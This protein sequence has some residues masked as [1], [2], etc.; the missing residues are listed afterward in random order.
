MSFKWRSLRGGVIAYSFC[1]SFTGVQL[2]GSPLGITSLNL[3]SVGLVLAISP[4]FISV[5][6]MHF[7]AI[8]WTVYDQLG[9]IIPF[10]FLFCF[11]I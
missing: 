10:G 4:T 3:W 6:C 1:A 11:V 5:L 7:I 2:L 9:F 8:L